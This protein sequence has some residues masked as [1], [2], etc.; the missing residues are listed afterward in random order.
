M[1]IGEECAEE[2]WVRGLVWIH[3]YGGGS[4]GRLTDLGALGRA[5]VTRP[6]W[7]RG[8]PRFRAGPGTMARVGRLDLVGREGTRCGMV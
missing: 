6:R 7:I 5:I 8:M 1:N 4:R 3:L 2:D